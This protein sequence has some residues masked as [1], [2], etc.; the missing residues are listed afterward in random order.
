[1][2][3]WRINTIIFDVPIPALVLSLHFDN[4]SITIFSPGVTTLE[5]TNRTCNI[6]K[7]A[8]P[9]KFIEEFGLLILM[10]FI[11]GGNRFLVCERLCQ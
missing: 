10:N 2:L 11:W 6:F 7:A 5:A 1:M 8:F 4:Q 9:L 3:A